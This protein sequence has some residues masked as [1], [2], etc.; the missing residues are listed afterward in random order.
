[1]FSIFTRQKKTKAENQYIVI[2]H[3]GVYRIFK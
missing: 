1:L 3:H 2:R